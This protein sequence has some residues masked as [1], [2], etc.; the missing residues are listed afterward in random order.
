MTLENTTETIQANNV[1]MPRSR[2]INVDLAGAVLDD[3]KLSGATFH[4]V[5]LCDVAITDADLSGMTIEGV[6]VEALFAAYRGS[7]ASG[8]AGLA[9]SHAKSCLLRFWR[10]GAIGTFCRPRS[11]CRRACRPCIW[12]RSALTACGTPMSG[13]CTKRRI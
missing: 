1:A 9:A 7:L 8:E 6:L 10:T 4:N 5:A 2:F 11:F 13:L 3:V 12:C